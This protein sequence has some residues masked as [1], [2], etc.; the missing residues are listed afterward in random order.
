M[1]RL[2]LF[3]WVLAWVSTGMLPGFL[4]EPA[5]AAHPFYE[6]RLTEG[7][8]AY[9]QGRLAEAARSF[10][11]AAFGLLEE[12]PRLTE[13]LVR[14]ALAQARLERAAAF[15]D[16]VRRVAELEERFEAYQAAGLSDAERS[17]FSLRIHE[18]VPALVL[19]RTPSYQQLLNE[20]EDPQV[21][22]EPVTQEPAAGKPE[23]RGRRQRRKAEREA[24]AEARPVEPVAAEPVEPEALQPVEQARLERAREILAQAQ[25]AG[26]LDE[27]RSLAQ[28]LA[29]AHPGRP[30]LQQLVGEIAYRSSR[31]DE[32]A[33]YLLRG[34]GRDLVSDATL[35][36]ERPELLFYLAVSLY[37]SGR[38]TE[39]RAPLE[40]ALP[41]IERTRFVD[42]Y[43]EKILLDAER[44]SMP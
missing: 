39:A 24:A 25:Q 7:L 27:A 28:P 13:T 31:W 44:N 42:Q 36:I 43:I 16:T 33:E 14:L 15:R 41:R 22:Q 26:A 32:A 21:A 20:E 6:R 2:G 8:L 12:P 23:K 34:L 38:P 11:I 30:D 35:P 4:P 29:D 18:L 3:V 9:E 19:T 37:E 5:S 40:R 1:T 17:A 10:E